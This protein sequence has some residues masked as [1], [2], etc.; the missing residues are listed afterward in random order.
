[1]SASLPL[2]FLDPK[3]GLGLRERVIEGFARLV[4]ESL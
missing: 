2:E 4:G 1:V 3:G